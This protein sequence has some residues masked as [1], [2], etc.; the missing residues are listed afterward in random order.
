[1]PGYTPTV[2]KCKY[3]IEECNGWVV[4][5][6]DDCE[7]AVNYTDCW[8]ALHAEHCIQHTVPWTLHAN[9]VYCTLHIV[10]CILHAEHCTLHAEN[11]TMHPE[12]SNLH[13]EHGTFHTTECTLPNSYCKMCSCNFL[14]GVWPTTNYF[15]IFQPGSGQLL[16]NFVSVVSSF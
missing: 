2:N 5:E 13:V 10:P 9:T 4:N 6:P 14:T 1:M 7:R 16:S 3:V 8:T 11:C 15:V 12:H